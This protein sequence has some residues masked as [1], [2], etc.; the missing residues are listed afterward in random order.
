MAQQ[1]MNNISSMEND[2]QE[3]TEQ[4]NDRKPQTINYLGKQLTLKQLMIAGFAVVFL[5]ASVAFISLNPF[6]QKK[7]LPPKETQPEVIEQISP[8]ETNYQPEIYEPTPTSTQQKSDILLNEYPSLGVIMGYNK[9]VRDWKVSE[10][11]WISLIGVQDY[12]LYEDISTSELTDREIQQIGVQFENLFN[13]RG[14][15]KNDLNTSSGGAQIRTTAFTQ[16][17]QYCLL[18]KEMDGGLII[19]CGEE[20]VQQ[21][22]WRKE[23]SSAFAS[24]KDIEN[25]LNVYTVVGNFA[26]GGYIEMKDEN[27]PHYWAAIK[28]TNGWKVIWKGDFGAL[29]CDI[30]QT[31][32]IPSQIHEGTCS[33][34]DGDVSEITK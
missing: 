3:H 11:Q 28:Q 23:L 5:L 21:T 6:S 2:T 16:D 27:A 18:D 10:N 34:P 20:D 12:F 22:K 8:P 24:D 14:F 1:L 32:K 26:K 17:S 4:I 7:E 31:Y 13:D 25:G 19:F 30:V 29:P 15:Q 9:S 33:L